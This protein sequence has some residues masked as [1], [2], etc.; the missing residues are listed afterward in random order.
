MTEATTA[1]G[2]EVSSSVPLRAFK[3]EVEE[4]I[5]TSGFEPF[6]AE[7]TIERRDHE[8]LAAEIMLGVAVQVSSVAAGVQ[9]KAVASRIHK[10]RP[11]THG[12]VRVIYKPGSNALAKVRLEDQ[13]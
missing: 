4:A 2:V 3:A 7:P 11:K 10:I 8:S 5:R 9:A 6:E 12:V 1:A 13:D